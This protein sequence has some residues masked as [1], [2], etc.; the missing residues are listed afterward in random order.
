IVAAVRGSRQA[1]FF[2][3]GWTPLLLLTAATSAQVNGALPQLDWLNDAS[4]AGGAFEALVLSLG[5][6]DRALRLRQDRDVVQVLADHDPLTHALNR[7]AWNQRASALLAATPTRPIALLFL[8]LDH[9][10][11]LNDRHGQHRGPRTGRGGHHA[12]RRIASGRPVRA[13]RR[14][15]VCPPAGW[16]RRRGSHAGGHP[17]VSARAPAG[18][19][20]TRRRTAPQHQHRRGH[21]PARRPSGSAGGTGRP[22]DVSRQAAW[23]QPRLSRRNHRQAGAYRSGQTPARRGKAAGRSVAVIRLSSRRQVADHFAA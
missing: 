13:I 4:L 2:L 14:R 9:F 10:K 22:G 8:D 15:G 18:N 5:L 17:P 3:A 21:A 16:H 1:W 7:R 6:A 20:G 19:S 11:L 23:T 12:R